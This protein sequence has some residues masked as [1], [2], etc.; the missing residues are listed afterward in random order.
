M[1]NIISRD[2]QIQ[3]LNQQNQIHNKEATEK[4]LMVSERAA[5]LYREKK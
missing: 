3:E 1:N 4:F 2:K 5:S